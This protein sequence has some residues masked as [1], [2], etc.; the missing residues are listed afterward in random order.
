VREREGKKFKD[1]LHSL[2]HPSNYL[3]CSV[4]WKLIMAA[5]KT[6]GKT[7]ALHIMHEYGFG[8]MT[9]LIINLSPR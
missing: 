3:S 8:V 6:R 4:S 9:P 5:K 1:S 2:Q 7:V